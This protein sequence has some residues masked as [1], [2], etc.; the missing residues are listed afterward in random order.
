[1]VADCD[2]KLFFSGRWASESAGEQDG[3]PVF[4]PT[5]L[6]SVGLTSQPHLPTELLNDAAANA[7]QTEPEVKLA[8]LIALLQGAS[9]T[10][11]NDAT[12]AQAEAGVQELIRRA[13]VAEQKA[14]EHANAVATRDT[15]VTQ[16]RTELANAQSAHRSDLLALAVQHGCITPAEQEQWKGRLETAFANERAALIALPSKIKTQPQ[17]D[18]NR[19][20]NAAQF[21]NV[22]D[23]LTAY[24]QEIIRLMDTGLSYDAAFASISRN[25][26]ELLGKT[27]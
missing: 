15:T 23:R 5:T 14:T 8:A 21:A 11:A 26:P 17:G 6:R 25:K 13:Q 9:V 1:M 3:L 24:N 10:I 20:G 7:D 4:R 22:S 12:E 27:A 18:G 2:A 16:L 19:K